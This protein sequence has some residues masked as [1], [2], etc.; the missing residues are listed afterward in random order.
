MGIPLILDIVIGLVFIYL[1][2]SLLTSEIQEIIA[3]LL[4]WRAEHLKKS[5]E[6]LLSGNSETDKQVAKEFATK[7]YSHPL[8]RT[9]NQEARGP[10]AT[11]FRGFGQRLGDLYR[12]IAQTRN[13]FGRQR[14]GPS[15][16]PGETFATTL[17]GNLDFELLSQKLGEFRLRKFSEERLKLPIRDILNALKTS[18]ANELL[19]DPELEY[20]E[21][22]LDQ[23]V[24]DFVNRQA[25]LVA[26]IDRITE[27]VNDFIVNVEAT[28][29]KNDH[30]TE[31]FV[32]RL[33]N[34]KSNVFGSESDR[35]VL[36]RK[37]QPTIAE[38][39]AVLDKSSQTY[40]EVVAALHQS[41]LV[42]QEVLAKFESNNLP[43]ELKESLMLLAQR[44]QIKAQSAEQGFNQLQKEVE[45]W[46]DRSMDRASGVYRR[47]AKGIAILLGFLVASATN[48]DTL[49]IVSRLSKDTALRSVI[50]ET[51]NQV[52]PTSAET[53]NQDVTTVRNAVNS[54]LN[55]LPLPIGWG[56][57]NVAQQREEG[58]AW[59][60]PLLSRFSILHRIVGW[61][62]SGVALSMGSSFW[63]DLLSKVVRVRNSGR[64]VVSKTNDQA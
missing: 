15:Y 47:N 55:E 2:L 32:K 40:Q 19:L 6:V 43:L 46:F 25:S 29:P 10:I 17:L 20:L 16:I 45:V 35:E 13:I 41:G 26:T 62:I 7:L 11:F 61:L 50:T 36:L 28:L 27:Q 38:V 31:T 22:K 23:I 60:I 54:A 33:L 9:L 48:A 34:L 37:L 39:V 1:I 51:A 8:I 21:N 18:K 42:P 53:V 52:A 14:S 30:R 64:P 3:T 57:V 49:H 4:Q 56:E 59:R 12:Q 44:A 5:I 58:V 63:F 24:E